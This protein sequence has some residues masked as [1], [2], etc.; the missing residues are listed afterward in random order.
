MKHIYSWLSLFTI[1]LFTSCTP[2]MQGELEEVLAEA[3][4]TYYISPSGNDANSGNSPDD[5]WQTI[6]RVNQ[7]QFEPGSKILFEGGKSFSGNLYFTVGDGN[8]PS[9][10]IKISSYGSG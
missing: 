9:K 5:A 4:N 2:E 10:P 3:K 7:M 1:L 6:E 8:D